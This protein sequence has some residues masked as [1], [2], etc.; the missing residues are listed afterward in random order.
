MSEACVNALERAK[1]LN[2]SE[3]L[4]S[5]I[6][7]GDIITFGKAMGRSSSGSRKLS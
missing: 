2:A 5:Q 4:S 1:G 7:T 3:M 6:S